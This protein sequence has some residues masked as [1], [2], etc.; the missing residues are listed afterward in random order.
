MKGVSDFDEVKWQS[1]ELFGGEVMEKV[2]EQWRKEKDV[3][4]MG[5]RR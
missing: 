1:C 2:E 3:V 5:E 4:K